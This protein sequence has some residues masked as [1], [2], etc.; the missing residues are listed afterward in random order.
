M[1]SLEPPSGMQVQLRPYQ[2][3]GFDWL[4]FL[5]QHR[6]G[7]ILADDMGLGKT[8]QS[9]ALICHAKQTAPGP[10]PFLIVAPTTAVANP[11]ADAAHLTP[12]LNVVPVRHTIA[13][14][15]QSVR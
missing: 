7:G 3:D 9:L 13:R 8:L 10:P 5:W 15:G 6:L 2:R 4:V 14:P 1:G 12:G 11:S